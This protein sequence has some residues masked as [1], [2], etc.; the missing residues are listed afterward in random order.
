LIV[1]LK[2]VPVQVTPAVSTMFDAARVTVAFIPEEQ[3][4]AAPVPFAQ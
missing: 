1:E 2:A 4:P 3:T